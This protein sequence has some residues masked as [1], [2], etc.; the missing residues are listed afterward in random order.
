MGKASAHLSHQLR[1]WWRLSPRPAP[2]PSP[3]HQG[4][5]V[6]L[7]SEP[8]CPTAFCSWQLYPCPSLLCLFSPGNDSIFQQLSLWNV[9]SSILR[10]TLEDR[11]FVLAA[12]FPLLPSVPSCESP[13]GMRVGYSTDASFILLFTHTVQERSPAQSR[14]SPKRIYWATEPKS[15]GLFSYIYT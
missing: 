11:S 2:K 8:G 10:S 14:L 1:M 12:T 6:L 5:M 4:R 13:G 3:G 7:S 9:D 15:P